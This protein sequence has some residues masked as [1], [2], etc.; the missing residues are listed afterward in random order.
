MPPAKGLLRLKG[1]VAVAQ[2][3]TY[4]AVLIGDD[5]VGYAVAVHIAN[6][7]R[8]WVISRGKGLLRLEGPIAIGQQHAYSIAALIGDHEVGNAIAVHVA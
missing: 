1:P 2:Q 8:I 4:A 6:R 7:H 5:E 3:H